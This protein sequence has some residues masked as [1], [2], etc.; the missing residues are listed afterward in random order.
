MVK[1]MPQ[2]SS[3][4]TQIRSSRV[5]SGTDFSIITRSS[6][7]IK[8]EN[9]WKRNISSVLIED[10]PIANRTRSSVINKEE[11][12]RKL[13]NPFSIKKK[14]KINYKKALNDLTK[15]TNNYQIN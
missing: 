6:L 3:T 5:M 9:V 7:I 4:P 12:V 13:S 8:E 11:N 14:H 10:L 2:N 1:F 15:K